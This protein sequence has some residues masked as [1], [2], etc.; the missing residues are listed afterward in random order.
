[1]ERSFTQC[2]D[3]LKDGKI[4]DS[5]EKESTTGNGRHITE[6]STNENETDLAAMPLHSFPS[7]EDKDLEII[8]LHPES[9]QQLEDGT[10]AESFLDDG[11]SC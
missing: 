4:N 10:I 2:L 7:G 5:A 1:M 11:K 9:G 8:A 3:G 6:E